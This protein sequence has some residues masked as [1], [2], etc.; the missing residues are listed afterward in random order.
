M[1]DF[2]LTSVN[3]PS[4]LLWYRRQRSCGRPPGPQYTGTPLRVACRIFAADAEFCRVENQVVGDEE[5]Q[6]AVAIV[7]DPGAAGSVMRAGMQ[8]ARFLGHVGERSV[9]VVVKQNVLAPAGDEDIVEAVVVV[10]AHGD[11]ARPRRCGR[12]RISA[13]RR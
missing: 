3:V 6:L 11:A 5:I 12:G 4:P 2:S 10:I 7:I 9:A 1:P 8:Q 13:S